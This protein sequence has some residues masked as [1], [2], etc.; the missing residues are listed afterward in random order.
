M[1]VLIMEVTLI[2]MFMKKIF[3]FKVK[4]LIDELIFSRKFSVIPL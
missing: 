2:L 4:G 3:N 1:A